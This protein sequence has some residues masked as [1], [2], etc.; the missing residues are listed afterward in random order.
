MRSS[1]L[2]LI[3][4][5]FKKVRTGHGVRP[6]YRGGRVEGTKEALA[7]ELKRVFQELGGEIGQ[8]K[9]KNL[10]A[11]RE[12]LRDSLTEGGEVD[13]DIKGCI[14]YASAGGES[15]VLN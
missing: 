7:G 2:Y 5:L 9:A 11:L 14:A 1:F 8:R 13:D 4:C 3:P 15:A 6:P 10:E 12:K